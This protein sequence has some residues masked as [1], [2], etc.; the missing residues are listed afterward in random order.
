M[1]LHFFIHNLTCR[2]DRVGK[3]IIVLKTLLF[4]NYC[5]FL[6]KEIKIPLI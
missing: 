1:P 3:V 6:F 5:M 4:I 2:V